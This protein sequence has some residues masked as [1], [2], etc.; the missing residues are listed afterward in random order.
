MHLEDVPRPTPKADELL[1]KVAAAGVNPV[2]YKIREGQYPAVKADALPLTLGR[3]IAG[4]VVEVGSQVSAYKPGDKVFAMIG[5]DG[6]YA[7]Y[8]RVKASNVDR[9]PSTMD[10]VTAAAIPLAALTA[11]QALYDQ[12]Q[13]QPNERVLIHGGSGGVGHFAIQFARVCGAEVFATGSK[14]SLNFMKELGAHHVIDYKAGR[15]E[16]ECPEVDL[17]ID[18]IGGETQKRSWDVLVDGGRLVSTLQA[19]DTSLPQAQGKRGLRF[20]VKPNGKQ[21]HEIAA[22][23]VARQVKPYV[24]RTFELENAVEALH[25]LATEHVEGKIVLKVAS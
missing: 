18:L 8:A 13:L 14:A 22:L 21:L 23:I 11:W 3:E 2:D 12:G 7:E 16:D 5:A 1:V 4:T 19:P 10:A 20:T 9:I 6:G 17:V 15:F 25:Y 24:H